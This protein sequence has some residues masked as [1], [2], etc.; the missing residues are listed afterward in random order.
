V[1]SKVAHLATHSLRYLE[2]GSGQPV[3]LLHAFPLCA[4]QWLPQLL[5]PIPGYRF[6]APDVRGFGGRDPGVSPGG[7]SMDTY[8]ADILEFMAHVEMPEARVVGTSMGG[9]IALAMLRRAP[10]RVTGLILAD[11][12]ASADS[13]DARQ[14]RDTMLARLAEQ[15]VGAVAD[16]MLPR[17]LAEK[18]RQSQPDLTDALRRLIV[19]NTPDGVGTAIRAMRDR[20]DS[21]P[22]LET[23]TCPTTVVV[24]REDVITPPEE[25]EALSRAIPDA[26]F[27]VIDEAGHLP[28]IEQPRAFAAAMMGS[29]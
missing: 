5:K 17:L 26:R 18:T 20:P 8:A 4:E 19:R 24:G 21:T 29:L 9:Y 3:V 15:G 16:Q 14:A 12:R 28:N 7:I 25:C 11:T 27:V 6:V 10:A 22:L 2:I 1:L 23:I 13:A